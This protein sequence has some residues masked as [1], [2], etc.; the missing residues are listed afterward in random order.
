MHSGPTS[1]KP[2]SGSLTQCVGLAATGIA[3]A[4][5]DKLER[6][7]ITAS[8]ITS[9]AEPPDVFPVIIQTV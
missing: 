2:R 8:R 1:R 9:P 6:Y 3:A 5:Y 4:I 7:I